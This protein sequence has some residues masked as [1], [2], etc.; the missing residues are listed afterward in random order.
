MQKITLFSL[1][2]LAALSVSAQAQD[3]AVSGNTPQP[4]PIV[5]SRGPQISTT[6]PIAGV[7]VRTDATG[8]VRTVSTG[9]AGTELRVDHGRATVEVHHPADNS[10]ITV[11]LPGGQVDLIKDGVYTFNADTNTARV[12]AGEADGYAS[13]A[14]SNAK[15]VKIKEE[16]ELSFVAGGKSLRA[17]E[18]DPR[19]MAS[20]LVP[21][22]GAGA[23]YR[24]GYGGGYAAGYAA[25]YAP[26]GDGYAEYPAYPYPYYGY[27]WGYPWGYPYPYVG[28]G[29]GFYGGF[30]GGY[31]GW[32]R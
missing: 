28:L 15:P 29:F 25:G 5:R 30:R 20:D 19:T 21:M 17:V 18:V 4:A 16:H 14:G 3:G 13:G 8:S 6:Q 26:Y 10:Q 1:A 11:D 32:R 2:A 24:P 31:G 23:G 9:T 22:P 27:G 7:W 12:L